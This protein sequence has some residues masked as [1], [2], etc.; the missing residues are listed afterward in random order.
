MIA[1]VFLV[2][3][4]GY[5]WLIFIFVRKGYCFVRERGKGRLLG[6]AVS[7]LI[8]F[9]LLAPIFWDAIPTWYTHHHLCE[10]QAGLKVYMTPDQWAKT[11]PEA[12][13][14]IRESAGYPEDRTSK[15]TELKNISSYHLNSEFDVIYEVEKNYGF[16]VRRDYSRLVNVKTGQL[17]AERIDFYGGAS[18]GSI[19]TGANSLADYKIWLKTGGCVRA[20]P[21]AK[22]ET[23]YNG[24]T[25][26]NIQEELLG[27]NK[28]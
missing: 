4:I 18:G 14:R 5:F 22:I 1:L 17:L 9:A 27:W 2:M 19:S 10:T 8:I 3:F 24:K 13:A 25:F 11:N 26:G 16:G 12:Y 6:G 28:K 23:K 20:Y 15:K 21:D 7:I